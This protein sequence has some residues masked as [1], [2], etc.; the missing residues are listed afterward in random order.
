MHLGSD[1]FSQHLKT[2]K[3]FQAMKKRKGVERKKNTDI[4]INFYIVY[5]EQGANSF[6]TVFINPEIYGISKK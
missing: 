4:P 3:S 6:N 5:F 2:L 1:K